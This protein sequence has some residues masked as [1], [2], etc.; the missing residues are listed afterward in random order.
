MVRQKLIT[1][2]SLMLLIILYFWGHNVG[3]SS[4]NVRG[5]IFTSARI[6]A[7]IGLVFALL[8]IAGGIGRR[9]VQGVNLDVLSIGERVV[10]DSL[11]GL[12]IISLL[13]ATLGLIGQFNWL[14]WGLIAV[15][16]MIVWRSV[17]SWLSDVSALIFRS[18]R[19]VTPW[20]RFVRAFLVITLVS[21]LLLALAPT[22]AW[23]AM[24]YH[25]V[26]P[27]RY[28]ADGEIG[29]QL[30]NHFF[31]FPQNIEMLFGLLMLFGTATAPAVLHFS[32]GIM[33]LIAIYNVVRRHASAKAAAVSVLV[34][35]ASFNIWLLMSWAYVDLSLMAYGAM[36]IIVI[37]QWV[38]AE[39]DRHHWLI[40][41]ALLASITA[42]IKYTSIPL[43]IAIYLLIILR[44]P[45]NIVRN[46]LIFG[47]FGVLLFTP[48]LVKGTLLYENPLYPYIFDGVN[49]DS[50]RAENF[51]DTGNGLIGQGLYFHIPLL[52]FTATIFGVHRL[53]PYGFT[54]GAFVLT[55][56]FLLLLGYGKL[57]NQSKSLLR[58]VLPL[59]LV[60]WVFWMVIASISGIGGQTRLM[61]IGIALPA[62]LSGLA[63]HSLENW[64][65]RPIDIV[66]ITQA[67]LIL[68]AFLG[69]F[70]YLN[71]FAGSRVLEYHAAVIDEETYLQN[72][73][74][75][76]Y[77]AMLE[78]ET[79][80]ADSRVLF[81]WEPKTYYC[82]TS[83]NCNG[84]VLF[85]NW[86]RPLQMGLS[87][88]EITTQWQ[89]NYDYILLF[90]FDREGNQDGY[91]RWASFQE[92]AQEENARFPTFI[93]DNT[94][95]IWSD[96]IAYT[97]YEWQ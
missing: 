6:L 55:M 70:D 76:L 69:F 28:I 32:F 46:T 2:F 67:V 95:E 7:D 86:S 65:R 94:N 8:M 22:F 85:D 80:P 18:G 16:A 11:L 57:P 43:I 20:E 24:N 72:N 61:L 19:P 51:S 15:I 49:W 5:G 83:I 97:L 37:H 82:P 66:F 9:A 34:L 45:K 12:G 59:T 26:I 29:Q 21:A 81:L 27:Q 79:L 44:D 68:S 74:G 63:F 30:D 73:V 50:I 54:V 48:W 38:I 90:D 89:A 58:T 77:D 52:P 96:G 31:G 40:L 84:D 39:K 56:P 91:S 33:G 62:I 35:M 88:D 14:I 4:L 92:F 71:Y 75:I 64:Q 25:L 87:P 10:L 78:L 23:D 36:V 42:G 93:S 1:V 60:V 41:A 47:G 13:S 3:Q 53:T 17:F